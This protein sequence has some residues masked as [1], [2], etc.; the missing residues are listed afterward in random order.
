MIAHRAL[1][2]PDLFTSVH[3]KQAA[4]AVIIGIIIRL[5]IALPSLC[6]KFIL[7]LLSFV[8]PLHLTTWDDTVLNTLAFIENHV[9][10]LP[11]FLLSLMRYAAPSALDDLFMMSLRWVDHTYAVKHQHQDHSDPTFRPAYYPSL[12]QYS[13]GSAEKRSPQTTRQKIE[14]AVAFFSRFAKKGSI[15]LAVYAASFIPKIGRFVLPAASF[16]TFKSA[17]GLGPASLIFGIGVFLPQRFLVVFLQSYFASRGLV[18]ELLEPYFSRIPFTKEE[19]KKWFRSRE[20]L[21]FGFGIG[22]YLLLRLPLLGVLVYGIAEAST[23]YLITKV[24]DPPPPP[25]EYK[26]FAETQTEWRNKQKFLNLSLSNLDSLHDKPPPYSEVDPYPAA[27]A[28]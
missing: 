6:I 18:R 14:S 1:Q 23:A 24:S 19:K 2:N 28:Q 9:L 26:N 21:L 8:L 20:G 7:Y 3:Y 4:L 27:S 16:W 11:L 12:S 22:F 10:Q 17:V 15:S 13:K 5:L 25:S